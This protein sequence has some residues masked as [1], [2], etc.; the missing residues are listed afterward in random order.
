MLLLQIFQNIG[1]FLYLAATNNVR[2]T[3]S[4]YMSVSVLRD[5]WHLLINLHSL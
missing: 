2:E 4:E 1:M 3:K 5:N